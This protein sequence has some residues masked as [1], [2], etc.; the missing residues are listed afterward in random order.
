MYLRVGAGATEWAAGG[1]QSPA[2]RR[3]SYSNRF[4][5]ALA[6]IYLDNPATH[7]DQK[8]KLVKPA[9]SPIAGGPLM[10]TLQYV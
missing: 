8:L 1:K 5:T 9:Y 7:D 10:P 3:E 4:A 2:I 6:G